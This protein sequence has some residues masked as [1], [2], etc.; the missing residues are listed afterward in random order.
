MPRSHFHLLAPL[1]AAMSLASLA[2]ADGPFA[3]GF[4]GL[5]PQDWSVAHFAFDHPAFDTDWSR[6][7][8]AVGDGLTLTLAPQTGADNRFVSA[9]VR[10]RTPTHFGRYEAVIQPAKGDGLVTGFFTY[11]GPY[12]GTQHD[13]IDIEFLGRDTTKLHAAWFVDG[14][15]HQRDI[16]LGFDAATAPRRYGFDWQPDA[17]T[18]LVDGQPI[19]RVTSATTQIPQV[20]GMM[21]VNLWAVD[22]SLAGW[23]GHAP[24]GTRAQAQFNTVQFTPLPPS[25]MPPNS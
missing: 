25:Q 24:P 5:P 18:W 8:V 12:Y 14:Q 4:D 23:A 13:E 7:Q 17:I 21:F 6:R 15:L 22:K 3:T 10:R 2:Q 16:P 20:P 9:S 11:T 1:V 19:F